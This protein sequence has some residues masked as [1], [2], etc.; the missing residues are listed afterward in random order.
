MGCYIT[1]RIT[2]LLLALALFSCGDPP[3]NPNSEYY[4]FFLH[5]RFLE[6]HTTD[7][8]HPLYGKVQYNEILAAF[9]R[10][11]LTVI[12]EL[13]SENT[14]GKVYA[15]KVLHQI[16]SLRQLGIPA[17]NITVIGTSKGG[18][19]AQY[20]STYAHDPKLSFV[21][22]GSSFSQ[23][24]ET[25]TDILLCGNILNIYE[26]SDSGSVS[27]KE[28]LARSGR[29]VPHF[30]ELELNTG[31]EHGFLFVL[32]DDWFQPS[33]SWSKGQYE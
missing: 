3:D 18:Y 31:K 28:M 8:A 13:R 16:D 4:V 1:P 25:F 9:E 32:L 22:I 33:L 12:S 20:V 23:D 26:Q 17:E 29:E 30:R 5:N 14:D 10:E 2:L 6:N 21:F 11:G 7:E 27:M 15:R 19:I 24:A